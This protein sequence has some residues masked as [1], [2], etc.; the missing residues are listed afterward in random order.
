MSH[1]TDDLDALKRLLA[2]ANG[3]ADQSRFVANFLL[4]WWN[5]GRDGGFDLTDLWNVDEKMANDMVSV[6]RIVAN[7]RHYADQYGLAGEFEELVALWRRPKKT[8]SRRS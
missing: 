7:H 5:G 2:I 1:T 8:G 3:T 6:F 4:A